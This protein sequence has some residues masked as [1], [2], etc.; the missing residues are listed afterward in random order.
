MVLGKTSWPGVSCTDA[1][2]IAY[3]GPTICVF[4]HLTVAYRMRGP[5]MRFQTQHLLKIVLLAFSMVFANW[6][7]A[8]PPTAGASSA[9]SQKSEKKT[10]TSKSEK[11][12][13][14]SASKEE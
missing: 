6:A 11:L 8:A 4:G 10:Q 12:D 13:V 14:N 2:K 5:H 7:L 9:K 3:L 1:L